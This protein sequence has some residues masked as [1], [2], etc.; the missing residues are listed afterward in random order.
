MKIKGPTVDDLIAAVSIVSREQYDGN[1]TFNRYPEKVGNFTHFTL[2]VINSRGPGAKVSA[3]GR[4]SVALCWHGHRDVMIKLFK[5]HPNALLVT[6]LARYD[7]VTGFER[8]YPD[9]AYQNIGSIAQPL[10]FE[11]ACRCESSGRMNITKMTHNERPE[12][13]GF[14][15][16]PTGG[17]GTIKW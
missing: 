13:A 14:G 8:E 7:G 1:I 15:D 2:R 3:S 9:T 12:T 16:L 6:A 11:D 5:T 10:A 4:R 17:N